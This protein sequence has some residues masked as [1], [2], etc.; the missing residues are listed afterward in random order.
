MALA[1]HTETVHRRKKLTVILALRA[2][3]PK[4][5]RETDRWTKNQN[6]LGH[7]QRRQAQTNGEESR[8]RRIKV[9]NIAIGQHKPN[10]ATNDGG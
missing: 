10:E 5:H 9:L 1:V 8:Q 7:A 6:K 2:I 3:L 4:C